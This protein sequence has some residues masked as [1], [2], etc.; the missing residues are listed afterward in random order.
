MSGAVKTAGLQLPVRIGLDA[1]L[2]IGAGEL[3][4]FKT[5]RENDGNILLIV[6]HHLPMSL[7]EEI[8]RITVEAI[9]QFFSNVRRI[10]KKTSADAAGSMTPRKLSRMRKLALEFFMMHHNLTDEQLYEHFVVAECNITPDRVRHLRLDLLKME[11]IEEK[12]LMTAKT[13]NGFACTVYGLNSR[14]TKEQ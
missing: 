7:Q 9:N 14:T 6:H 8:Q 11:L 3:A 4:H 10:D 5:I 12:P 2:R 13:S 1:G